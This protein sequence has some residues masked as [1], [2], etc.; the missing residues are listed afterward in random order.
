MEFFE[1]GCA[2][3]STEQVL[4]SWLAPD[5]VDPLAHG[6]RHLA[7]PGVEDVENRLTGILENAFLESFLNTFLQSFL[8][9]EFFEEG[10]VGHGFV[11]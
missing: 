1:A 4:E 10:D 11:G 3:C 5:G 7:E 6:V 8:E 2:D 9:G